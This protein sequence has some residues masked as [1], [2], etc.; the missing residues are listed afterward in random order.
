MKHKVKVR[1][2]RDMSFMLDLPDVIDEYIDAQVLERLKGIV[3]DGGIGN[4]VDEELNRKYDAFV[5]KC[6]RDDI[7]ENKTDIRI[8]LTTKG[9]KLQGM[10]YHES[11][12]EIYIGEIKWL[13]EDL[14]DSGRKH[15]K[16][17]LVA[18]KHEVSVVEA[19]LA[20]VIKGESE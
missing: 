2:D 17:I 18:L 5:K 9:G 3:S 8:S 19:I 12:E 11:Y 20:K 4:D 7:I 16:E 6:I 13:I 1:K 14:E 15:I 10:L